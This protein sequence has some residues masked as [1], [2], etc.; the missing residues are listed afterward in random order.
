MWVPLCFWVW[1]SVHVGG[2]PRC[3]QAG[4]GQLGRRFEFLLLSLAE[5]STPRK[6]EGNKRFGLSKQ[7]FP[8]R[9][10]ILLLPL[11]L[12]LVVLLFFQPPGG[13]VQAPSGSGATANAIMSKY[14]NPDS[15]RWRLDFCGISRV[16]SCCGP[17]VVHVVGL[18]SLTAAAP[19]F[20]LIQS[21]PPRPCS[22]SVT[23]CF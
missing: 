12:L 19:G 21:Q 18:Y 17:S 9:S 6:F 4:H 20:F 10:L 14:S 16:H 3:G 5:I 2:L 1:V 13:P 23:S 7:A 15:I 8:A 22:F 11:L